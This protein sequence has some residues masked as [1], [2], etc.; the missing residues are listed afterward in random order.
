MFLP[1]LSFFFAPEGLKFVF[2]AFLALHRQAAQLSQRGRVI[3]VDNNFAKS[4]KVVQ[5]H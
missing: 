3:S 4:L 1:I 5:G 2:E